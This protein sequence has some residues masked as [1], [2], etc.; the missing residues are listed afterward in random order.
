MCVFVYEVYAHVYVCMNTKPRKRQWYG[1]LPVPQMQI[2][3][4]YQGLA[5]LSEDRTTE[6]SVDL[7]NS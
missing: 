7:S 6:S 2:L 3:Y 5:F 4:L 1:L